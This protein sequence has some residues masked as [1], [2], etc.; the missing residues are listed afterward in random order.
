MKIAYIIGSTSAQ[1]INR[2][3]LDGLIALDREESVPEEGGPEHDRIE[4]VEIPI[5]TLPLYNYDFDEKYPPEAVEVK[6]AVRANA[7]VIIAT[8][9]YNRSIPGAL[10]NAIDWISR[11]YGDNAWKGKP[12]G[13]LGVSIGAAGTAMA[14]Q[15]LRNILAYLDAPTLGQ[16]EAFLEFRS[17]RFDRDGT[18]TDP[19][20]RAFLR[21]WLVAYREWVVRFAA[22]ESARP[23]AG[24]S[25]D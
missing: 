6:E 10:K 2:K 4:F 1:S 14:Q 16:P 20:T 3:V 7:G 9:E 5:S 18:P 13:I 15:H 21:D 23:Q 25:Q 11:P 19:E 24:R 8:P 12:V 22:Q 17:D